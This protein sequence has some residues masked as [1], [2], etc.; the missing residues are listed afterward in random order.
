[1]RGRRI[2]QVAARIDPHARPRW[3][4]VRGE[5]PRA[6]CHDPRL[7]GE[8]A[9]R[10]DRA[11]VTQTQGGQ[12]RAR[13]EPEL[14]LDQV[15]AGDL[16]RDRV[17]DLNARVA[18]DEEI[19]AGLGRDEEFD[20]SRAHVVRGPDQADRVV[21][22][23][24]PDRGIERGCR[25]RFHNFLMAELYRAVAL[26]QVDDVAAGV[27]QHLNLDVPWPGEKFLDEQRTVSERGLGLAAATSERL[28]HRR[29]ALH[30]AHPAPSP[31]ARGLEHHRISRRIRDFLRLAGRLHRRRTTR[32]NGNGERRGKPAGADFISE[33]RQ[34]RGRRTDECDPCRGAPL[35]KRGVLGQKPVARMD[36]VA[37]AGAGNL[38]Q[39][40]DVEIGTDRVARLPPTGLARF[41]CAARME[42][43][44]VHGRIHGYGLHAEGCG[45][46]GN[47]DRDFAAVADQ[48]TGKH[49]AS[50]PIFGSAPA[51]DIPRAYREIRPHAS[52]ARRGYGRRLHGE[53]YT[54]RSPI[55][56]FLVI[57]LRHSGASG[58][59]SFGF[60]LS[61]E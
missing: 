28:G 23:S 41:R 21:E 58:N 15:D 39:R 34:G 12:R 1:M 13:G 47:A 30:R 6:G 27:R 10:G 40:V 54:R 32:Q 55:R 46:L 29:G 14:R 42:R 36:A 19:L 60:P 51:A 50:F 59:P 22:H 18:L 49:P 26:V 8:A 52:N 57:P 31:A 5:R 24:L 16:F 7:Y 48:D 4:L 35:G 25:R 33:Q 9:R 20:R 56:F 38:Y 17:F 45:G 11:L 53:L 2:A 61:W 37:A 44:R 3:F 43:L